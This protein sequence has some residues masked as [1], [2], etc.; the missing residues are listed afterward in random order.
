M[1]T[2]ITIVQLISAV[3]LVA[4]VLIQS[5]KDA[6]LTSVMGGS[7]DTFLA[8]NKKKTRDARLARATKWIAIVFV[9]LTLILT[10]IH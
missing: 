2:A 3:I 7:S 4:V 1:V 9:V 8:R 10:I 6:G 5:G